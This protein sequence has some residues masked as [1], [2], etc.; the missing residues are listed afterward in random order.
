MDIWDTIEATS[1]LTAL[2]LVSSL[3]GSADRHASPHTGHTHSTDLQSV[4]VSA[5]ILSCHWYT[6]CF[7]EEAVPVSI[8]LMV[9]Q[10]LVLVCPR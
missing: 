4:M 6:P 1:S 5:A 3:S 10:Y 9:L 2:S 7:N 8:K